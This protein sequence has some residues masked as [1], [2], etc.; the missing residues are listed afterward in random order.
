[1]IKWI[2]HRVCDAVALLLLGVLSLH[3]SVSDRVSID[4][5]GE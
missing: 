3:S 4:W 2:C 1:M 5:R